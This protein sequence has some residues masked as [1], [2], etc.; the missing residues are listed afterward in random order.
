MEIKSV[1][2]RYVTHNYGNLLT[3]SEPDF[4]RQNHTWRVGIQ[5]DYPYVITDDSLINSRLLKFLTLRNLGSLTYDK[6]L[7]LIES[8]PPEECVKKVETL[9]TRWERKAEEII[10]KASATHIARIGVAKEAL[11]PIV[12]VLERFLEPDVELIPF[13]DVQREADPQRTEMWLTLLEQLGLVRRIERGYT[14]GNL[15]TTMRAKEDN[16]ETFITMAMAHIIREQYPTLRHVF[17]ITRLETY[18]HVS[19]CY[20]IPSMLAEKPL[21]RTEESIWEQYCRWY[22]KKI[23]LM[24]ISH[25][26]KEMVDAGSIKFD[27]KYYTGHQPTFKKM[28]LMKHGIDEEQSQASLSTITA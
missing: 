14:Y 6:N 7:K 2:Q 15:F 24:R 10:V 25:I 19:N 8:T 12:M 3:V 18:V 17:K 4:D 13:S 27:G 26:L 16:N 9:L 21:K 1:A 23:S 28:L 20:Y 11:H 22:E 5:S